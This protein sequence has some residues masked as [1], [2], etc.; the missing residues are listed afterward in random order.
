MLAA[1]VARR[2]LFAPPAAGSSQH[3]RRRPHARDSITCVRRVVNR[4][5]L[6]HENSRR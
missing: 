6:G 3:W 1:A 4:P 5:L 2:S